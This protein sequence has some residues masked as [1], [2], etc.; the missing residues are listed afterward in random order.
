MLSNS[1]PYLA[2]CADWVGLK[3]RRKIISRGFYFRQRLQPSN[4]QEFSPLEPLLRATPLGDLPRTGWIQAGLGDAE[5][6]GAHSHGVA[7]VILALGTQIAA[8]RKARGEP[9]IDIDRALSLATVHDLGEALLGDI[10]KLGSQLLPAGAKAS[11]ENAAAEDL[12][13]ALSGVTLERWRE[14]AAGRTPEA[15]LVKLCDKLQMGLRVVQF[16]RRGATG[17]GDFRE[18]VA[19]LDCGE[20]QACEALQEQLLEAINGAS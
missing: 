9:E 17:L 14:F 13:G 4:M 1:S 6:I 15:R 8:N 11:A 18:S 5:S 20:F 19:L 7:L 2:A 3:M 16:Q 10:P 12:G